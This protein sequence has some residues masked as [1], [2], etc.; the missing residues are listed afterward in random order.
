MLREQIIKKIST[1]HDGEIEFTEEE[2]VYITTEWFQQHFKIQ[3][4]ISTRGYLDDIYT[5]HGLRV[6]IQK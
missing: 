1:P 6:Q 2:L 3:T 5:K 4:K